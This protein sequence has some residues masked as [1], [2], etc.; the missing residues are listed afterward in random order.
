[1]ERLRGGRQGIKGLRGERLG[2][3]RA[4]GERLVLVCW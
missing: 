2:M 1:M 3:D 4:R